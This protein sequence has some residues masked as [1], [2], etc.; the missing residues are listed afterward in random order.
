MELLERIANAILYEGYILYP[1]RRSAV[2]NRQRWNFGVLYPR[3]YAE[4]Q[5]GHDAWRMQAE[6]LALSNEDSELEVRVRF[7]QLVDR[8]VGKFNS[9]LEEFPQKHFDYTPVDSLSVGDQSFQSWQEAVEREVIVNVGRLKD[10]ARA[11]RVSHFCFP[12]SSSVETLKESGRSVGVIAR[13]S[14]DLEGQVTVT[15][16]PAGEAVF[17][18]CVLASNGLAY[19]ADQN[20]RDLAL[21]NSMLSAHAVLVLRGGQFISQLDPPERFRSAA[22]ACSNLGCWPVLIG[23]SGDCETMLASPIILYDYP[24]V[25]EES[26]GDLFDGAEIDEILSLRILTLTDEEK[27]EMAG[28][29]AFARR[30]LERTESLLPDQFMKLHGVMR[31]Q[32]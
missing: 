18:I 15:S 10:L 13:T 23:E 3:T 31:K 1:Y 22:A 27:R 17:K 16:E 6:C 2:K 19:R 32:G 25:A 26:A 9:P 24:Q 29:D 20:D 11:G 8:Q 30:I 12:A 4:A 7:L 14:Y 5:S 21:R 28:T